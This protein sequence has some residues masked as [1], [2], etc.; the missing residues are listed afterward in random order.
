MSALDNE[1]GGHRIQ[2]VPPTERRGRV[3]TSTVV[4]AVLDPTKARHDPRLDRRSPGDFKLEWYS[5]SGAGGQHRNKHQNSAR[6]THLP[7]GIVRTAQTRDRENSQ[8]LAIQAIH[9]ALDAMK[10]GQTEET[11]HRER[12]SQTGSGERGDKRR[13]Y[14]FQEN[15]VTDHKT[16]KRAQCSAL[17][18]GR[19]DLLW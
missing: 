8:R 6:I 14:R 2:R 17:M 13:T 12:R 16:G 3:H 18:Q 19:F 1:A 15:R 9:E 11:T 4:V 5:G 7:T 10:S